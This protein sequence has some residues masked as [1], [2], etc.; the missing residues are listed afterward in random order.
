LLL[1]FTFALEFAI[2]KFQE[3]QEELELNQLL[4]IAYFGN[5]LVAYI[6][7]FCVFIYLFTG[8]SNFKPGLCS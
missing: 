4:I 5:L 2:R 7:F 1:L 3:N 8:R 6:I